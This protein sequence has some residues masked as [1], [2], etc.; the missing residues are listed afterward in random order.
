MTKQ[1]QYPAACGG[2]VYW[3]LKDGAVKA[4]PNATV[5]LRDDT[6]GSWLIFSRPR[7]LCI[8]RHIDEVVPILR[9]VE[10]AVNEKGLC[11]A[12]FVSYEAAPAFDPSLAVKPDKKFPA[13]LVWAL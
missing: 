4:Q 3:L 2:V 8:A 10:Q 11:A 9:E 5:V 1:L 12:G 13:C 7:R 6:S